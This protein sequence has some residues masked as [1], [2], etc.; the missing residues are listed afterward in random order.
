MLASL[1]GKY[2]R[3]LLMGRI[4]RFYD[5]NDSEDAPVSGYH[6]QRTDAWVTATQKRRRSLRI[7]DD[8]FERARDTLS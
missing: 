6:D 2:V 5:G 1:V 4:T 8:C 3:E 7:L